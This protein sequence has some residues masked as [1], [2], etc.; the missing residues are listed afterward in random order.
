MS[1]RVTI[2]GELT[3]FA[4]HALKEQLLAALGDKEADEG[5]DVDLSGVSEIDGAGIQLLLAARREAA[6]RG[7]NFHLNA[8][9]AVVSEALA[10]SDLTPCFMTRAPAGQ[11]ART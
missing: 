7:L 4:V 1:A 2:E 9:S 6:Q 5:I 10:L 3:V 8:P 11:E